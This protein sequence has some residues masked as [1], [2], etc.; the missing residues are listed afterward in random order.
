MDGIGA[1]IHAEPAYLNGAYLPLGDV[2]ISPLDRGFIF[3]DAIY[4]VIPVYRRTP[5]L[6]SEHLQRMQGN[7]EK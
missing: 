4:E 2:R 3:G 1:D 5:F 6:L 7:L